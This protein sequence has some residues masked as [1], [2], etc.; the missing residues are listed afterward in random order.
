MIVLRHL[1]RYLLQLTGLAV[2]IGLAAAAAASLVLPRYLQAE[3]ALAKADYIVPLA[4][5]WHRYIR[6]ADLYRQGYAP[7]VL[8]SNA[9][10]RAPSRFDKLRVEM[11]MPAPNPREMRQRLLEHL[12]IAKEAITAFGNGHISTI[13]EAE[14]LR[15]HLGSKPVRII[16][17]TSPFHSRRARII[18]QDTMPN[19]EFMVT[20]PPEKRIERRWWRDQKSAQRVV[21]ET[22]KLVFYYLGGRFR[23]DA[24]QP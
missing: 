1:F 7:K 13:E 24:A 10:I 6:A 20:S 5:E 8:V 14:A 18:F 17:V 4:G 2:I 11:G 12:G 3:D 22:F 23:S 19:G 16:L 9:K 15:R 21:S